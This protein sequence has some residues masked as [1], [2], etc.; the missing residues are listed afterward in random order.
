M[1][2][3]VESEQEFNELSSGTVV[4]DFTASWC[5]PCQFIGPTFIKIAEENASSSTK[6]VKIDVDNQAMQAVCQKAGISCMPTF[7][8][9]KE[10][11]M[12]EQ[13]QGASEEKLRAL[14]AKY[15]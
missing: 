6:F 5:G 12:V 15:V 3:F 2:K 7:Q 4:I 9:W 13:I 14:V 1:V 10:G 11:K 8:V